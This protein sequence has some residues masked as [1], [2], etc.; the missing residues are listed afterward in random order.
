M[1][2]TIR[3]WQSRPAHERLGAVEELV[4]IAYELKVW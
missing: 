1:P 2:A 3:S 4:R